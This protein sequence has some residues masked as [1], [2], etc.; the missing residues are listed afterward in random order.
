MA[1]ARHVALLGRQNPRELSWFDRIM[2]VIGGLTNPDRVAAKAELQGFDFMDKSSI[3][4]IVDM[5]RQ[6]QER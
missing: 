1:H 2:L 6:L 4:P 3:G 5:A